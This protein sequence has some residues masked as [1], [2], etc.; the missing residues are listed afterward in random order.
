MKEKK[1]STAEVV[2]L[3]RV[4]PD[5]MYRWIKAEKFYVPPVIWMGNVQIR[6]WTKKEVE[7]V[8]QYKVDFYNKGRGQKAKRKTEKKL[9]AEKTQKKAN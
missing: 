4:S 3:V 6:L 9:K 7:A 5:T 1:Y 2:E 8:K